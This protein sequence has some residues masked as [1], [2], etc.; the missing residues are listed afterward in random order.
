MSLNPRRVSASGE[1]APDGSPN[2][3]ISATGRIRCG[4][5]A[6]EKHQPSKFREDNACVFFG[7]RSLE[8]LWMLELGAWSF[9]YSANLVGSLS[10][11]FS[12]LSSRSPFGLRQ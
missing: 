11:S 5:Q 10:V 1:Y 3:R 7:I 8:I 4:E 12:L 6:P 2:S 9:G